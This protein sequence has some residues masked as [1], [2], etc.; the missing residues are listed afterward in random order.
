MSDLPDVIVTYQTA[1]DR[2]DASTALAS[3]TENAVV[4]DDG[5]TYRGRE[6]VEHWLNA[7]ASEFTYTRTLLSAE[8]TDDGWLVMNHIEGDFPGGQVDLRYAFKLDGDR[9]EQLTIAP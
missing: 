6:E 9:I 7:A 4:E 3:F 5:K 2:R 8:E 1:H